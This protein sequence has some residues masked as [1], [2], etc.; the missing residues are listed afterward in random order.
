[1]KGEG[2]NGPDE[3][4]PALVD[5]KELLTRGAPGSNVRRA[6]FQCSEFFLVS[7]REIGKVR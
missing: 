7:G 2:L 1:M 3:G 4:E 6:Q 5:A